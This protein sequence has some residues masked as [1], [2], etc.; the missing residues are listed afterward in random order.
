MIFMTVCLIT[1]HHAHNKNIYKLHHNCTNIYNGIQRS[2]DVIMTSQ[3][4]DN[5]GRSP[6]PSVADGGQ[7]LLPSRQVVDKMADQ[8]CAG[9]AN[10]VP[11]RHGT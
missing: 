6:T 1:C 11:K 8:S 9:H 3:F 7:S 5:D 4:L 2:D 10:G